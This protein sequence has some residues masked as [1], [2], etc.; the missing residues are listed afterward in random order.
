MT[1]TV[2]DGRMQGEGIRADPLGPLRRAPFTVLCLVALLVTTAIL[3]GAAPSA[4]QRVLVRASTNLHNM[5][6]RPLRALVES[7]FWL[8]SP[9]LV[10]PMAGL[11]LLVMAPVE[12]R[13]GTSRTLLVFAVGHVGATAATVAV[14]ADGVASGR[15]PRSLS[16][17]VDVGPSYGLAAVAGLLVA[18][19]PGRR[20]RL[21]AALLIAVL[22]LAAAT[23]ADFTD[24]GHLVA[25]LLGLAV[26][27]VLARGAT[28]G[29]G[30]P[31]E[32]GSGSTV[33]IIG[34]PR[35]GV[36]TPR[37]AA[38]SPA[39]ARSCSGRPAC[40]AARARGPAWRS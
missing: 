19:L 9:W 36:T 37:R 10:A 15:L 1:R 4:A 17:A 39:P 14:I 40:S 7:A 28:P 11:F 16:H 38:R 12:R 29:R 5:S 30:G 23:R 24:A 6:S 21:A 27:S 33:A 32:P 26:A 31:Q 35:T 13:F 8:D 3:S 25:A 18:H 34:R 22:G 2:D 20:A